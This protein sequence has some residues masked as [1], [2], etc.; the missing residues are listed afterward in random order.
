[1][2]RQVGPS[3]IA[4]D[5]ALRCIARQSSGDSA[6]L[7]ASR[8]HSALESISAHV[9]QCG[10]AADSSQS[11]LQLLVEVLTPATACGAEDAGKGG[12]AT[13]QTDKGAG[14][15]SMLECLSN[16]G[17]APS[18]VAA[19]LRG[20]LGEGAVP[21]ERSVISHLAEQDPCI[22]ALAAL[23][24]AI[25]AEHNALRPRSTLDCVAAH[26]QTQGGAQSALQIVRSRIAGDELPP[27]APP[28]TSAAESSSCASTSRAYGHPLDKSTSPHR[29]SSPSHPCEAP[30]DDRAHPGQ[31]DTELASG[32]DAEGEADQDDVNEGDALDGEE[33]SEEA[34]HD[35]A[36]S[37][38]Y[39]GLE[40]EEEVLEG[41]SAEEMGDD[42]M[43]NYWGTQE[44]EAAELLH[45]GSGTG[46]EASDEC[47][48]AGNGSEDE[49]VGGFV[50]GGM[51]TE[52]APT[53][54]DKGG[55]E[56]T[57]DAVESKV[58]EEVEEVEEVS[59]EDLKVS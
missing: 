16:Y 44:E 18:A 28:A 11:A 56:D 57:P 13:V 17:A 19:V 20:A 49:E 27:P 5:S 35:E 12:A 43:T 2:V 55:I 24:E 34:D 8:P 33:G 26:T 4:S 3:V 38:A 52:A 9:A 46:D 6:V 50:S 59:E 32:G 37:G 22:S 42:E 31:D 41:D 23:Q 54:V 21:E 25:G 39:W 58:V 40:G 48:A 53:L 1:M 45:E 29:R 47:D 15:A 36:V 51:D 10:D 7:V 30:A 14:A